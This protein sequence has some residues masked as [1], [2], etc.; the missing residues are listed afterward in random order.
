VP[1]ALEESVP[2]PTPRPIESQAAQKNMS[3]L[4]AKIAEDQKRDYDFVALQEGSRWDV[5]QDQTGPAL[6]HLKAL[7]FDQGPET[8]VTLYNDKKYKLRHRIDG[9]FENNGRP[10]Q[11]LVFEE[12]L[13]FINLH[14]AH[15]SDRTTV[16]RKLSLSLRKTLSAEE[17][18]AIKE[19]R[20]I[21]AGDFND[22]KKVLVELQPFFHAGIL[23]KV[24]ISNPPISCCSNRIPWDGHKPGD[25]ILDSVTPISI[26][27]PKGYDRTA[28]H[29]D[30]LPVLGILKAL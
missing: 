12:R 21:M 18:N 14:N 15:H 4:L 7:Y 11:I 9:G 6:Q 30:H 10:F 26:Q 5:L 3:T 17:I 25:Y 8:H 22:P 29:S 28:P 23:T 24:S 16:E 20:I 1:D 19:F 13:I 27:V 2:S